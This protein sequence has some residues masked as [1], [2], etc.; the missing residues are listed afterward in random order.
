MATDLGGYRIPE[1][2]LPQPAV[3]EVSAFS[4]V[5]SAWARGAEIAR[6]VRGQNTAEPGIGP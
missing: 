4:R 5:V 2:T 1:E 6:Q 3:Y